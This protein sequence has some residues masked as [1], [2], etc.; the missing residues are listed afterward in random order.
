MCIRDRLVP[1]LSCARANPKSAKYWLYCKHL[2]LWLLPCGTIRELLPDAS[3]EEKDLADFWMDKFNEYLGDETLLPKWAIRHYRK[4]HNE[5]GSS[6]DEIED[7]SNNEL[8]KTNLLGGQVGES[9]GE[10]GDENLDGDSRAKR[11]E[12][13]FY[14]N[15]EDHTHLRNEEEQELDMDELTNLI[16]ISN[17]RGEDFM[18]WAKDKALPSY[19]EIMQRLNSLKDK[20]AKA[21]K[22]NN[23]TLNDKQK[24]FRDIVQ[25]WVV[26]WSRAN[27]NE[28][29]WPKPLR[30]ILMGSP[31][32]GKSRVVKAT[33]DALSNT[34]GANYK[35][36]VRQ[37][38]PT[39]CASFQ[40]SA[41]ATTV[42]KLFGLH[43]M[44]KSN[45]LDDKTIKMLSEKFK[46]G[47]CLLVIDEFSMESR[48][49]VGLIISRL[50]SAYVDLSKMGTILIG[51]PAQLFPTGKEPS[52][53][54]KLKRADGKDFS[55]D[56]YI[57]LVDFRL[58][59][60]CLN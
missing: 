54:I 27:K 53:S 39:G 38:T 22:V 50:R 10:S 52:W 31:G 41:G 6:S 9:S 8:S 11:A 12:N 25:D 36:V 17:P 14:Q 47:L 15:V 21:D 46:H 60:A 43:V 58:L 7:E 35:D 24:L 30:L 5:D 29:P 49:M 57:G 40:M 2:C 45:D 56:S 16:N 23:V 13:A 48:S 26:Q 59:I 33:M 28:C 32:A 51:D 1:H 18:K 55:D 44:S 37:A 20:D 4:Y 19:D 3:L 34:L 42:H